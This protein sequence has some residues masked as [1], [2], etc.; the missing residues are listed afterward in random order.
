MSSRDMKRHEGNVHAFYSV[1]ED[2]L[3][4]LYTVGFQLYDV[5]KKATYHVLPTV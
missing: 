4:R 3:K 5:L 1:K 2:N